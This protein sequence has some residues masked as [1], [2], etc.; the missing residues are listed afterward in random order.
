MPVVTRRELLEAGVHFGHQTRRWNPK[1]HRYLYGERSGIYIIDLEKSL[2]GIEETY[3]FVREPG[4]PSRDRPV[5]RD[6]EAGPGGHLRPCR[7]RGD[8][9]RHHP[10]ARRDAHELPDGLASPAPPARAARD[11]ANG[12]VRLPPQARGDPP[13]AREGEARAQPRRDAE[14]RT[15]PRRDLRDRHEEGAH[16]GQRG[17]QAGHLG[18][19]DRGHELR[20]RRGGLRDPGQRRRDPLGLA[21]H[22]SDRGRAGRGTAAG[23]R[24]RR[25]A[26]HRSRDRART[27]ARG[28]AAPSAEDAAAIAADGLRAG[29]P[30]ADERPR[31]SRRGAPPS[32]SRGPI[33]RTRAP[34]PEA[35]AEPTEAS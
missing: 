10:L 9:I 4:A 26:R 23:S 20:S 19:R 21:G 27:R 22:S 6:Q 3:E 15:A 12:S 31:P 8:A 28:R 13:A 35:E 14:P 32:P 24:G 29:R 1:M 33:V 25:H 5:R 17:A 34:A 2:S 30:A 11:G 16:R 7:S 18:D